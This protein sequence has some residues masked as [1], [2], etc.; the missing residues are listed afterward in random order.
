MNE[1]KLSPRHSRLPKYNRSPY[2]IF[3]DEKRAEIINLRLQAYDESF[4]RPQ[5]L[6]QINS[7]ISL[8]QLNI[9]INQM[10]KDMSSHGR[11]RF[12]GRAI[13][14]MKSQRNAKEDP[15]CMYDPSEEDGQPQMQLDP[16]EITFP[17]NGT[18]DVFK[19]I[20]NDPLDDSINF[21]SIDLNIMNQ[22]MALWN[23]DPDRG[24]PRGHL[25]NS[26][27][28]NMTE[29]IIIRPFQNQR[30]HQPCPTSISNHVENVIL[31]SSPFAHHYPLG[32]G[33]V[34]IVYAPVPALFHQQENSVITGH[35]LNSSFPHFNASAC[36]YQ[37]P[38]AYSP[39]MDHRVPRNVHGQPMPYYPVSY[40]SGTNG[41]HQMNNPLIV[42]PYHP[43]PIA[44]Y[45]STV[46][47]PSLLQNSSRNNERDYKPCTP[48]DCD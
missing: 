32:S 14:N 4:E 5:R 16:F 38:I 31:V 27:D 19:N 20:A 6:R 45:S 1:N 2:K 33:Q 41:Y 18:I 22:S 42:E 8:P 12:K 7:F 21:S 30:E 17:A 13:L 28:P 43:M 36:N 44:Y 34:P 37:A 9:E 47:P 48:A 29:S 10:W 24:M 35:G 23:D 46:G 3:F 25:T 11:N 26:H 40:L 39:P 15:T